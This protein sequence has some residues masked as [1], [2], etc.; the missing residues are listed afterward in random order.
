MLKKPEQLV[1]PVQRLEVHQ[2]RAA[3]VGDVGDVRAA[4]LAAGEVPDQPRV[5]GAEDRVALLGR[6]ADPVDVLEDPLDLAAGEVGRRGQARLAPDD[7]ALALTVEGAGDPVGAGVLPDDRVVVG[8]AGVPVPDD[9]GLALVGDAQRGQVAAREPLVVQGG[10]DHRGG[11]LPDLDRV[12]L[13]PARLRQ[14]LLVLEL[15]LGDLV[16]A[17][18]EEHEAGAGGALVDGTDEISHEGCVLSDEAV[19]VG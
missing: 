12:V 5:G 10:L 3:G 9:R 1:V 4:V 6:L 13:D 11:A 17:V 18:V 2:H 8:P 7:V 14:D 16:A 15:V 19:A